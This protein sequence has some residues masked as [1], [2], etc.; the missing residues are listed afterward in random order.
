M[1]RRVNPFVLAWNSARD[2]KNTVV[3]FAVMTLERY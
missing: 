2:M 1:T 3:F